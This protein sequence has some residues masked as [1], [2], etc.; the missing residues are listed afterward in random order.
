MDKRC[1]NCLNYFADPEGSYN[2]TELATCWYLLC[3]ECHGPDA[4][5]NMY[6][7]NSKKDNDYD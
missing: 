6:E 4:I 2:D 7:P 5:I 3:D 1:M